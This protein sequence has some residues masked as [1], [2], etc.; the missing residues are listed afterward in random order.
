MKSH[1]KKNKTFGH[2]Y[3]E[4]LDWL[5]LHPSVRLMRIKN[6]QKKKLTQILI[7][8]KFYNKN[9][10]DTFFIILILEMF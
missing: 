4:I 2:I 5:M 10:F 8:S 9:Y 7:E 6:L 1:R 3:C